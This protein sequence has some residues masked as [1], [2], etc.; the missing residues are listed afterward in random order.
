MNWPTLVTAVFT[1][2]IVWGGFL[3]VLVTAI[4]KER[5]KAG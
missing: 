1:L 4:R 2:G 3:V 5:G